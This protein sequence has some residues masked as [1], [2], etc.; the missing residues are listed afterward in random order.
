MKKTNKQNFKAISLTDFELNFLLNQS[1]LTK[2]EK[3]II[4]YAVIKEYANEQTFS[5]IIIHLLNKVRCY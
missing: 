2:N 3:I 1:F 4:K 5:A